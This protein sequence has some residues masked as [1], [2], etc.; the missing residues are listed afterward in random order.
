MY[1]GEKVRL[2]A[3]NERAQ[4]VYHRLGFQVEGRLRQECYTDGAYHDMIVMG[5]LREEYEEKKDL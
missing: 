5:L 4:K 2:R 3:F 1:T